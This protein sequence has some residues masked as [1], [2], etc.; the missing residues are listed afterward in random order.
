MSIVAE[1]FYFSTPTRD[2]SVSYKWEVDGDAIAGSEV[3]GS[4]I[5]ERNWASGSFNISVSAEKPGSI[6]QRAEGQITLR[7]E[8]RWKYRRIIL[9]DRLDN[10]I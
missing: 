4:T 9:S 7:T 10:N 3:A 2:R 8:R 5:T 6:F 1:P